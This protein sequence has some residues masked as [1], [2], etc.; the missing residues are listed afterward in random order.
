[1]I[2]VAAIV[3][4]GPAPMRETLRG[5]RPMRHTPIETLRAIDA[6]QPVIGADG[7]ATMLRQI[8]EPRL[9]QAARVIDRDM[10]AM[11]AKRLAAMLRQ[12]ARLNRT[13]VTL[14]A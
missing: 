11:N 5:H 14:R 10:A 9:M 12:A 6:A 13:G 4:A 8:A 1:M 7:F 2:P 3:I